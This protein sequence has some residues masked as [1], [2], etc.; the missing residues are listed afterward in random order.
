MY[1]QLA[2][3]M[4][5]STRARRLLQVQEEF[6]A[7]LKVFREVFGDLVASTRGKAN[8]IRGRI[9]VGV[10]AEGVR[11]KVEEMYWGCLEAERSYKMFVDG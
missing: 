1:S 6:T 7:D 2:G 8:G 9:G 10:W 4:E 11:G 3:Y 5:F